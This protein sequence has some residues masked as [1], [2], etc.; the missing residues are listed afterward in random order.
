VVTADSV[1]LGKSL[2]KADKNNW[3]PRFGFSYL[4]DGSGKTVLRGGYGFYYGHYSVA[5]MSGQVSGPFAVSTTSNN[6]FVSGSPL[7]TLGS[8]FAAPGSSG[9]LNLSGVVPNLLTMYS[10]QV[11]LSIER[12]VLRDLGVRVSY[13][14]TKGT[15]LA[16]QR[17]VNQ[18]RASTAPFAQSRRPYPLYNN[19]VYADNG[20]NNNYHGLQIAAIKRFSRGLQ[21]NSTFI[22]AKQLSEVD[23]T[24][25]AEIFTSIEDAYD[26]RRDRARVYS[27]P[28]YQWMNQA[29]YELPLGRNKLLKGWQLNVL[30]N[31][32]SGHWLNPQ[33]SGS[34]PSNTNVVGGRPDLVN[35]TV[36]YPGTL[37]AWFDRTAFGVPTGG[38]FGNAGRNIIEG[39]GYAVFNAG[40]QKTT[41]FERLGSVMVGASFQNVLNHVN[42]G[43]P[44]MTANVANGGTIT[45]THVFLPAGSPRTGQLTMRWRF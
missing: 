16:Y 3:A 36:N 5:A 18:P 26:R 31:L 35:T 15:Q 25:N 32:S 22:W 34:D 45:S 2:R 9:T 1:G 29:L 19:I 40:L 27:V 23:D 12:E 39:P 4:L 41:A 28:R 11:S 13:I 37:A 30:F 42:F 14:G 21:F 7:F 17:N 10:Q 20:A 43:Q 8:P 6:A 38:R 44:L 24:N 33:F